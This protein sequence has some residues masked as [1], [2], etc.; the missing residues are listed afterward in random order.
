MDGGG[1]MP[2]AAWGF[3][4]GDAFWGEPDFY[5]SDRLLMFVRSP[6]FS[7]LVDTLG[8][9]T[10]ALTDTAAQVSAA[11]DLTTAIG[12]QLDRIG[13]ILQRPRLGYSD[14]RYRTLLQIQAQLI[15]SS[16]TTTP[17]ILQIV[18]LFTGH[19][20]VSYADTYPMGFR[21]GA[22]L[23]DPDDAALLLELLH[24]A[25]AAA[26][27]VELVVGDVDGLVLDYTGDPI[28]GAGTTDY[29]GDPISG[30]GTLGYLFST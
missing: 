7:A 17:V 12:V 28:D 16:T 5:P 11:F 25:K 23:D 14:D 27:N 13:E 26:Y 8:D 10:I 15:L 3:E 6:R 18:A 21:I 19:D 29:A 1:V 20:P 22:T 9:R 4:W 2:G 24:E 30:A